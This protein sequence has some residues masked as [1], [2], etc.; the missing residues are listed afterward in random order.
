MLRDIV[1]TYEHIHS[2]RWNHGVPNISILYIICMG[3]NYLR[4]CELI[5]RPEATSGDI[6]TAPNQ[7]WSWL[8]AHSDM[9]HNKHHCRKAEWGNGKHTVLHISLYYNTDQ[10]EVTAFRG[11]CW[12]QVFFFFTPPPPPPFLLNPPPRDNATLN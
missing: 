7:L 4:L 6:T 11:F 3:G 1:V 5:D 2:H 10:W 8:K 9:M 12:V